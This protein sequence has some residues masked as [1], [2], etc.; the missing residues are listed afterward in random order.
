M[1]PTVLLFLASCFPSKSRLD[2]MAL[3]YTNLVSDCFFCVETGVPCCVVLPLQCA[4]TL[5][6]E[7]VTKPMVDKIYFGV[8]SHSTYG[9]VRGPCAGLFAPAV[10]RESHEQFSPD[11]ARFGFDLGFPRHCA[12][13]NSRSRELKDDCCW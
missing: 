4:A 9:I 13:Q 8:Y 7:S 5:A 10:C 3:Q 2:P 6:S 11:R 1:P 12:K